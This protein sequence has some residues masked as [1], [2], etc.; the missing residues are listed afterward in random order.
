MIPAADLELMYDTV[1]GFAVQATVGAESKPVHFRQGDADMLG[2]TRIAREYRM[3][4]RLASFSVSRGTTVTIAGIGY[5]VL[6]V[7]Q[8]DSGDEAEARMERV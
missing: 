2:G 5:R 3:R 1:N 6:E 4:Y 7:R 8:L